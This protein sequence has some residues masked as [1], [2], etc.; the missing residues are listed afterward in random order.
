MRHQSSVIREIGQFHEH[1]DRGAGLVVAEAIPEIVEP[2][3]PVTLRQ[4][5]V[6][7]GLKRSDEIAPSDLVFTDYH[8]VGAS[9][10]I[11]R[12]RIG[13]IGYPNP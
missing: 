12:L 5:R 13:G 6:Q 3:V 10:N 1:F 8:D 7:N 4:P 2:E 11:Q 9:S